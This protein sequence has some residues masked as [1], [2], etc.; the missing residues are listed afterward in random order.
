MKNDNLKQLN[1]FLDPE[2]FKNKLIYSSI[3]IALYESFK[4]MLID[5]VKCFYCVEVENGKLKDSLEYKKRILSKRKKNMPL[6]KVTLL[7]FKEKGAIDNEEIESFDEFR[8]LR[9]KLS[10]ELLEH[11][12]EDIIPELI[13]SIDRMMDLRHK[14][15]KWWIINIELPTSDL[16]P[17]K[18]DFDNICTPAQMMSQLIG[19]M[20]SEDARKASYYKEEIGKM[21]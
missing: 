7:W 19:D 4:D 6:L 14:I 2:K 21:I 5:S 15:E 1:E 3:Y 10:H 18:I 8:K 9:N 16:D 17:N 11:L 13:T 20:L 12:Y